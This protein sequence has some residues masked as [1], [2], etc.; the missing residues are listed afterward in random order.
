MM[1]EPISLISSCALFAKMY[2][3]KTSLYELSLKFIECAV[4][5]CN[6]TKVSLDEICAC[7]K[8][9]YAFDM[10]KSVLKRCLNDKKLKQN[11]KYETGDYYS[12][13]VND[14]VWRDIKKNLEEKKVI[15]EEIGRAH[16]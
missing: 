9:V 16:V 6:K 1:N 8:E 10:P 5:S 3:A 15:Y 12:F 4:L 2:D 11:I 13:S 14:D 7:L